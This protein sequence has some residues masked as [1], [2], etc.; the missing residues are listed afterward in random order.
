MRIRLLRQFSTTHGKYAIGTVLNL[1]NSYA[2]RVIADGIAIA[3][4]GEYP[5]RT[6]LR[7]RLSDLNKK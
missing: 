1:T 2:Q 5:P 7:I 6:K 3:Y 4:T